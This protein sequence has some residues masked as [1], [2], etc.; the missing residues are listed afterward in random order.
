MNILHALPL[1]P[2]DKD[3]T[4]YEIKVTGYYN[5]GNFTPLEEICIVTGRDDDIDPKYFYDFMPDECIVD[6]FDKFTILSFEVI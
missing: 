6:E 4:H 2:L 1:L 3:L 5:D